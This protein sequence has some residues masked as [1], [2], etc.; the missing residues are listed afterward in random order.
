M[1]PPSALTSPLGAEKEDD[2]PAAALRAN[3]K[4]FPLPPG[5][6]RRL[7]RTEAEAV[8]A[9]GDPNRPPEQE[10]LEAWLVERKESG[11]EVSRGGNCVP[12]PVREGLGSA[13]WSLSDPQP[14]A[15]TT[16]QFTALVTE[17]DCTGGTSAGDRV[18]EPEIAYDAETVVVTF[19]VEPLP[20]GAYTCPG[21]PPTPYEV[22]L[23]EPLGDRR[24]L[25]GGGYPP[26][27]PGPAS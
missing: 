14:L 17:R 4:G 25:D 13:E 11:W 26:R 9:A 18:Y 20:S 22:R 5:P 6:W 15:S 24:L 7:V 27:D 3:A 23:R 19:W 21:N 16:K 1:F 2:P 10:A 8:Y 12:R